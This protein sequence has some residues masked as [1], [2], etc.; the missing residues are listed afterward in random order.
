MFKKLTL[1]LLSFLIIHVGLIPG[2]R[3]ADE[4]Q[5]KTEI[6]PYVTFLKSHQQNPVDYIMSLF[7]KHDMVI[8]CERLHPEATQYDFICT[9]IS[10]KRF[11]EKVGNVF[12][13]LGSSLNNSYVHDF[14]FS[15]GLQ[16]NEV[17]KR[18][19]H[20]YRN[21]YYRPFWEKYGFYIFLNRLYK[22]NNSLAAN[23]KINLYMSDIPFSWEGM[24]K[25]KYKKFEDGPLNHRDRIM[26]DQVLNKFAEICKSGQ[27]RKKALVI[28][29]YRHAFNDFSFADES[30]GD[31]TGRYIFEALRDRVA[32]VMLNSIAA[33]YG[34]SDRKRN[35]S[36]ISDGKWD[37]AFEVM[38]NPSVGFDF[39]ESPFGA[40]YFDYFTYQKHNMTYQQVFTGF[41]FYKP[42]R[43]H[44]FLW[45]VPNLFA[46][47]YDKIIIE[48]RKIVD[49]P[50]DPAEAD[51]YLKEWGTLAEHSFEK[52]FESEYR[53]INSKIN[54]WLFPKKDKQSQIGN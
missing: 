14:L 51:E 38:G 50:I 53:Q 30:K 24:T 20:I 39:E 12:T 9:L 2:T 36:P 41:V 27:P 45:G 31:N 49:S 8:L 17:E 4:I 54:Q 23:L 26:A 40:D 3:N 18:L 43:E 7:Q 29:N 48:R 34:S 16:D 44:Q 10:D 5:Y 13:E 37:A 28:M 35:N 32:N 6:S 15:S 25:E 22:L 19:L 11:I 42:L 47:G 52:E 21:F 33:F 1:L 46:D